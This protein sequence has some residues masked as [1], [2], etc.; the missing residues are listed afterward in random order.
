MSR[1]LHP[2]IQG[3][4]LMLT[5][6]AAGPQGLF[7]AVELVKSA[8]EQS[9]GVEAWVLHTEN[10][11]ARFPYLEKVCPT[12]MCHQGV[13]S[14]AGSRGILN[15]MHPFPSA[16]TRQGVQCHLCCTQRCGRAGGSATYSESR[17]EAADQPTPIRAA[18]IGPRLCGYAYHI[19]PP[20]V[21]ISR[22]CP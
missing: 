20:T 13:C 4:R 2:A 19:V 18:A 9:E 17:V 1:L 5:T 3:F 14:G 7:D 22:D 8:S 11:K 12:V 15:L 6:R 10:N 16:A 21:G